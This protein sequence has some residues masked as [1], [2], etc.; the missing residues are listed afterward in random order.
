MEEVRNMKIV[1]ILMMLILAA[2]ALGCVGNKQ[3][4]VTPT[5]T[6]QAPGTEETPTSSTVSPAETPVSAVAT[7]TPPVNDQFGTQSDLSTIDLLVNDSSMDIPLFD[8]NI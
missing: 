3:A 4:E 1:Y 6:T 2:S 7:T 5:T 8:V